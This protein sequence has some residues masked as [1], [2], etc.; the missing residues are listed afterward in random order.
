MTD[1]D[2]AE[3]VAIIGMA[4]ETNRLATAFD[5]LVDN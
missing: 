4:A 1:K 5:V 2:F 3:M